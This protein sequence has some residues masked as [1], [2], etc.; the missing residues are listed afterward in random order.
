MAVYTELDEPALHL[1]LDGYNLPRLVVFTG[2]EEGIE[3]SNFLLDFGSIK[4][5]LT[6][7]EARTRGK[8][9]PFFTSLMSHLANAGIPC[10]KPVT[11]VAVSV[12]APVA[13]KIP[14][15]LMGK[16]ALV[17]SFLPGRS[18]TAFDAEDCRAV[19]QTLARLHLAS[20]DF[21]GDRANDMGQKSWKSQADYLANELGDELGAGLNE[22]APGLEAVI[23]EEVCYLVSVWP[24]GL[25][26]GVIH[27]DLFPDNVMWQ[28]RN[29]SGILD[30][31]FAC[32]DAL[33]YDL[34]I[35]LTAWCFE[36]RDEDEGEI[37]TEKFR[38]MIEG[39]E[40]LRPLDPAEKMALPTLMRGAALRFLLSRSH[41][42]INRDPGAMVQP[43]DP[44]EQLALLN[45]LQ[46]EGGG[47]AN[48]D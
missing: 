32:T 27:A 37:N 4:Y 44:L 39:Y 35:T 3:N 46:R 28:G 31:Y 15:T 22:I 34:A 23:M 45:F 17:V 9:L 2:I 11:P 6:L 29:I 47:R 48:A 12:A 30:F 38:A 21:E 13:P 41:D 8:D 14:Q 26:D 16:P 36:A 10:P 20:A 42:W 33:A 25:P 5:I 24:R 43:R 19:G 1:F 18:K 40:S 7:F